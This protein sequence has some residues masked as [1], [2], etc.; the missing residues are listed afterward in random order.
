MS[1]D[2]QSI[3][4][5]YTG[6]KKEIPGRIVGVK[7]FSEIWSR[8]FSFR[9]YFLLIYDI[10]LSDIVCLGIT[11]HFIM[12]IITVLIHNK[13]DKPDGSHVNTGSL[14]RK[15]KETEMNRFKPQL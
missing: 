8:I 9:V 10:G 2:D 11:Q 13:Q 15:K 4:I 6:L 5:K 7:C 1:I 12:K 14:K 3:L